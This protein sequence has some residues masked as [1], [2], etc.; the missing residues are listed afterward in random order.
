MI[1]IVMEKYNLFNT[2]QHGFRCGRS[3]LSQLLSHYDRILELL[4]T[5]ASVD[6]I[7]LD[8]AKSFDKVDFGITLMKL[9][10]LGVSGKVGKWI[11]S[12]LTDRTL[13]VLVNGARSRKSNVQSGVPQGSV[14]GPLLFLILILFKKRNSHLITYASGGYT[15][16][17]DNISF[18][19]IHITDPQA[20]LTT[21]IWRSNVGS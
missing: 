8:F 1:L 2:S 18:P 20:D 4:E 19:S 15:A 11:Y 5:G 21:N 12:F 16:Q 7:Y 9:K 3:C 13:T 6:I 10:S 14:L 17:I